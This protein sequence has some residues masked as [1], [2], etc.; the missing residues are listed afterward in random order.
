MSRP[1]WDLRFRYNSPAADLCLPEQSV[2]G[3][4]AGGAE[5]KDT[6]LLGVKNT[7]RKEWW[8]FWTDTQKPQAGRTCPGK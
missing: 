3:L 8:F 5:V 2:A 6:V 4:E 7:L 1:S